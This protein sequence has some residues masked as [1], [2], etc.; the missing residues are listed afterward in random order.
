M[1]HFSFNEVF[2]CRLAH[3]IGTN[4]IT[5]QRT[6]TMLSIAAVAAVASASNVH[7]ERAEQIKQIQAAKP[8]WNASAQSRFAAQVIDLSSNEPS[9]VVVPPKG[10][11]GT[12]T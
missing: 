2:S 7:P 3:P 9:L 10:R 5:M 6:M 1:T 12:P 8:L 11:C 4:T